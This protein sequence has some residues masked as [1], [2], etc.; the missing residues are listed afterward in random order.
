VHEELTVGGAVIFVAI[1]APCPISVIEGS[2]EKNKVK[3]LA[4]AN[5]PRINAGATY[6]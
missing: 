1:S 4:I 3:I 5:M 6:K 2:T